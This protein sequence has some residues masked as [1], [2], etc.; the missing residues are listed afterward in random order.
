MS[1][2]VKTVLIVGGVAAAAFIV[3]SLVRRPTYGARTYG[4]APTSNPIAAIAG[5]VSPLL[6]YFASKPSPTPAAGPV[7]DYHEGQSEQD[8]LDQLFGPDNAFTGGV[9]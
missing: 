3:V 5:V 1:G 2:T 4:Q 6:S 7:A 8:Y 9:V